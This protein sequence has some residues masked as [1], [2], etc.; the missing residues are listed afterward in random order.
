VLAESE[1]YSNPRDAAK[2][3]DHDGVARYCKFSAYVHEGAHVDAICVGCSFVD[4]EWY[5]GLFNAARFI[6]CEF[7]RCSFRG[8][9]FADSTFVECKFEQCQFTT[10]NLG[11]GC[12]NN[13]S[14]LYACEANECAGEGVLFS[15]GAF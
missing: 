2:V 1:E 11:G 10:D 4:V 5:W 3:L 7:V 8:T 6:Q 9:S 13:G 14:K 12:S 15:D